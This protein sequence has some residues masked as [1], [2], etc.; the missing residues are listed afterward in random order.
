[1]NK[2]KGKQYA[3]RKRKTQFSE[4]EGDRI[5]LKRQLGKNKLNPKLST[6]RVSGII[7]NSGLTEEMVCI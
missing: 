2:V 4:I 7:I 5:L 1:M 6:K 3:D